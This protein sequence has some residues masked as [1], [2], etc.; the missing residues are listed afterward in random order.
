MD[1]F[2][3]AEDDAARNRYAS[4]A[5]TYAAKAQSAHA[6]AT[7]T[8]QEGIDNPGVNWK[9]Q[10]D[11]QIAT[12]TPPWPLSIVETALWA[13]GECSRGMRL[14]DTTFTKSPAGVLQGSADSPLIPITSMC[15]VP[16]LPQRHHPDVRFAGC[17]LTESTRG[18]HL[19]VGNNRTYLIHNKLTD[20]IKFDYG[21]H[22]YSQFMVEV[23][24]ASE[25]IEYFDGRKIADGWEQ[26]VIMF[27]VGCLE[28]TLFLKT[29][30][31]A[32]CHAFGPHCCGLSSVQPSKHW[33]TSQLRYRQG[34]LTLV[35]QVPDS[36]TSASHPRSSRLGSQSGLPHRQ[37]LRR[38]VATASARPSHEVSTCKCSVR[39]LYLCSKKQILI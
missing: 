8:L 5:Q 30:K 37:S 27:N 20:V 18:M 35:Q 15:P 32:L 16:H 6:R 28:L 11:E 19:V 31:S 36:S 1:A 21:F 7:A 29:E 26:R 38:L 34:R 14:L 23:R 24:D 4:A 2:R 9:V 13:F 17:I 33:C 25:V 12:G 10:A 3:R 39:F 22:Q